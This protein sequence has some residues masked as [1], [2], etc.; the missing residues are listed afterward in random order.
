M[1]GRPA[2]RSLPEVAAAAWRVLTAKGYRATGISDVAKE[3]RLSHGALY[4][5]VRSKEALLYLALVH[6]VR[7]D[8]LDGMALPVELPAMEEVVGLVRRWM[9][10]AGSGRLATAPDRAPVGSAREELGGIVDELYGFVEGN[11]DALTLIERCAR[12]VPEVFQ[13]WFVQHRRA[14]FAALS[15]YLAARIASGHLRAVPDVPTAARF[16]VETVAWFAWHRLGDADSA[17]LDD[18]TCRATVRHIVLAAF[19]PA[20]GEA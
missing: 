17:M 12:E 11:R 16:I 9:G 5:Y 3:L 15:R 1:A 2:T 14:S 4:T 10:D 18:D 13:I 19:L 8:A 20:E 6:S 7:A